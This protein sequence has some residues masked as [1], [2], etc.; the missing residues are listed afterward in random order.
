MPISALVMNNEQFKDYTCFA[1]KDC[2]HK[3]DH[4]SSENDCHF[5]NTYEK[6]KSWKLNAVEAWTYRVANEHHDEGSKKVK[7]RSNRLEGNDRSFCAAALSHKKT[8]G[9]KHP[10]SKKASATP[11]VPVFCGKA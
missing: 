7:A 9:K 5:R 11:H 1:F 4:V 10:T 8:S 3:N 2:T 6:R